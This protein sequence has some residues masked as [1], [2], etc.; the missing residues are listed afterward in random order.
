MIMQHGYLSLFWE[1][2]KRAIEKKKIAI[3]FL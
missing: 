3:E 1:N 2:I